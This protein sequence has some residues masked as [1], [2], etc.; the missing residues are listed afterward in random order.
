MK[1]VVPILGFTTAAVVILLIGVIFFRGPLL[2]STAALA[3]ALA[4]AGVVLFA[5][6][7]RWVR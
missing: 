2:Y 6:S 4:V 1:W 7:R 5:D 3:V